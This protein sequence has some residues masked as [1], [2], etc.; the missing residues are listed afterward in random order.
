[1]NSGPKKIDT[2]PVRNVLSNWGGF[3]FSAVVSFFL[4]PYILGKLG[5]TSY[6]IWALIGSL[7][8]YFGL[9]DLGVRS[10][11]TKFVAS[12]H[13]TGN[14][15]GAS[16]VKSAALL[17]FTLAGLLSIVV[18]LAVSPF[19]ERIFSIPSG[20]EQT[21]RIAIVIMAANI[22][23]A[24]VT[25]VYGGILTARHRF[26]LSNAV[27][28]IGVI[29]RSAAIVIALETSRTMAANTNQGII[30]LAVI[31]L[32]SS[33]VQLML[34]RILSRKAYR[35]ARSSI[36]RAFSSEN[37]KRIFSFGLMSSGLHVL[38]ST[39]HNSALI[40][41]GALLPVAMV[42]YYSIAESLA[43]YT[44]QILSGITHTVM[45]MVGSLEGAGQIDSVKRVFVDGTRY[46][47][48][49]VLPIIA[50]FIVRGESFISL[51]MGAEYGGLSGQILTVISVA[52]WAMVGYQVCT[53]VMIGLGRQ[54]GMM[55]IFGFEA[56]A[57]IVLSIVLIQKIGV[58]GS[59]WGCLIPRLFA[60]FVL[61]VAYAKR[62]LHISIREYYLDSVA[63]PIVA[64][65]PF[66]VVS[67]GVEAMWPAGNLAMFFLQVALVFPV[68]MLG[69]W[70]FGLKA[71]ERT[72]CLNALRPRAF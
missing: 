38:G 14:H 72:R 49:V 2:R 25:G 68:A 18:A 20:A 43:E 28:V 64:I 32:F 5:S 54:K 23:V 53:T 66:A 46:G 70:I 21:A 41:I 34:A 10:A 3:L 26:D 50:T 7:V 67:Y 51:W 4:G 37:L 12:Y 11:V 1:M 42:T 22:A 71:G 47:S 31:Q 17:A 56:V 55:P 9:L 16:D 44:R 69:C 59:A 65:L 29:V 27:N 58:L 8:G 13:S 35:E 33:V 57:N 24:L 15:D 60:A 36:Y 39:A 61:A 19:V 30:I 48:L 63:R 6:G 52:L 45:P 62:V 40:I